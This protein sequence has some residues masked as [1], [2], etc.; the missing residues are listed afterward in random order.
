MIRALALLFCFSILALAQK[1]V[2]VILDTDIGDDIDDALALGLALQSPELDIKLITTVV[3][4]VENRTRLVWKELG[5]YGRQ[6]IPVATGAAMPFLDPMETKR[7]PQFEV[8]TP[9]D[10][11]P[12]VTKARAA[13]KIVEV[14]MASSGKVTLLPIGPLTNIALALRLEPRIKDH[15]ERIILMGGAYYPARREYNIYR[16]RIAAAMVFESGIPITGVG[17]DVTEPC[18]LQGSDLERLRASANPASKFLYHLIELWQAG[19]KDRYPVLYDPLAIAVAVRPQLIGT[20]TG[21]V[22]V[23]TMSKLLYGTT[24]FQA[25]KGNT[26]AAKTVMQRAFLDLFIERVSAPPRKIPAITK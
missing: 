11:P 26:Q 14:L 3:D 24:V 6:D 21:T 7:M 13:D 1:P 10:Q 18:K 20:E 8:L 22:Q 12:L 19:K 17:L 25:G 2:P 16:D 15:I 5:L 9:A 4:D 23:E